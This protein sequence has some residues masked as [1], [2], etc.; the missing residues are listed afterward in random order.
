VYKILV[1]DD[2]PTGT[3]LLLTLLG[4]E[5]YKGTK[6]ENWADPL[7]DVAAQRPDLVIMDVHLTTEDGLDLLGQIREHPDAALA[8]L[9]VV[10]ISAEDLEAESLSAGANA[11]VEKPFDLGILFGTIQ[12]LMEGRL[13]GN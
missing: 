3:Q 6:L 9:P 1:I 4:L 8:S 12:R 13:S 10:M 7:G 5:G 2:D 11:F